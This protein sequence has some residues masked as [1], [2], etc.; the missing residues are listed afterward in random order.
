MISWLSVTTSGLLSVS[1]EQ[2]VVPYQNKVVI[3]NSVYY[4]HKGHSNF[5]SPAF[6]ETLMVGDL[7]F[8]E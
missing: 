1:D 7:V 5:I 4:L 3:L 6:Y 2:I 8:W